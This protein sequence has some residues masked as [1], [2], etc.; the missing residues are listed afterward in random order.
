MSDRG[1]AHDS[2]NQGLSVFIFYVQLWDLTGLNLRSCTRKGGA[3]VLWGWQAP[4]AGRYL[5]SLHACHHIKGSSANQNVFNTIHPKQGQ[6]PGTPHT[7]AA[8]SSVPGG[9]E[10]DEDPTFCCPITC[11]LMEDP[12]IAMGR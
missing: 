10:G 4:L 1:N 12:V 7:T 11:A 8:M 6:W 9:E 2:W 3:I 5:P